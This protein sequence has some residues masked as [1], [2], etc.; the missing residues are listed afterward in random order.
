MPTRIL[1]V[2]DEEP[3]RELLAEYLRGRGH[4]VVER[5]SAGDGLRAL[6]E[7]AFDLLVTDLKLPDGEGLDVVRVACA[8]PLPPVCVVM[9]GYAT[10]DDAIAVLTHGAVDLLLKP[11]R[12]RDAH[13]ALQR[14]LLRGA[15][16]R[17][18]ALALLATRWLEAS[19]LA[20]DR[21]AAEALLPA[22]SALVAAWSP[23]SVIELAEGVPERGWVALGRRRSARVVPDDA[24]FRTWLRAAHLALARVG[25]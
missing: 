7:Q 11:F 14:A 2:E 21:D 3:V 24:R 18:Q 20:E 16:A 19:V 6:A 1:I 4:H 13:A 10:V 25:A 17:E 22:L 9:S 12:L 5:S 15:E 23:A 8:R